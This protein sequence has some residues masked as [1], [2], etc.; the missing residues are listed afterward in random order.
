MPLSLHIAQG[1]TRR[2]AG[3]KGTA[4]LPAQIS[5]LRLHCGLGLLAEQGAQ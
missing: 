4:K 3:R 2:L 1:N 5:V